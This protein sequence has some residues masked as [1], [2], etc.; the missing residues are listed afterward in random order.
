MVNY[1][2]ELINIEGK[3]YDIFIGKNAQGNEDIIKQCNENSIWFHFDNISSCH[4]ILD[5]KG[6][7]IPKEYIKCVGKMLYNYKKNVPKYT[8]IIYTTVK[9]IKLTKDLGTVIPSNIKYL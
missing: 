9:N 2:K 4:I 8:R 5:S 3:D 1:R 7:K 6:D